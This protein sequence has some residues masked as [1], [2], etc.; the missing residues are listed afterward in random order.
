MAYSV[1]TPVALIR[2]TLLALRSANQTLPSAARVRP[3]G[4]ALSVGRGANSVRTAGTQRSSSPSTRSRARDG[5]GRVRGRLVFGL[6]MSFSSESNP[7]IAN[8]LNTKVA[9]GYEEAT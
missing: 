3:V 2:A 8:L 5:A 1:R 7:F 4:A 9:G 6:R